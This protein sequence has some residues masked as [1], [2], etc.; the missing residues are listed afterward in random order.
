[1]GL[2]S[3]IRCDLLPMCERTTTVQGR[4]TTPIPDLE[5]TDLR[6]ISAAPSVLSRNQLVSWLT[7]M[8]ELRVWLGGSVKT[9]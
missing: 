2:L 7:E 9:A 1:M 6:S 4:T 8:D 3:K 5:L